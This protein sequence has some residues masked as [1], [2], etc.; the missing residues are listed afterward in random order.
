M[1][2]VLNRGTPLAEKKFQAVKG[3]ND[4]LPAQ[5][6]YW[7][8]IENTCK[9]VAD[10]Y[11]YNEIRF[12]IVEH[13]ALFERTIGQ[14][15][16]IV[17]KEMYTFDDHG[18]S[19]TLRPEG[20]AGCVRAAIE[21]GLLYNQTQR[22]WYMGPMY[23]HEQPQKGRYRQFYQFGI[24]AFGIPGPDIDAEQILMTARIF[25]E[26]GIQNEVSLQLNSL[27]SA[28][29]RAE[30]R[31]KLISYFTQHEAALDPDSRRRLVVNPLR[32]LDSKLP[33]LQELI[34]NAPKL[35]DFL[36]DAS[37]KHFDELRQLLDN[38]KL[39]YEINPRLVRGLDYYGLTVY[40]WTTT[41][42]G[43]QNALGAG[44]RYD[45]LVEQ[46]G[47]HSTPAVG[48]ALGLDRIVALV[49]AVYTPKNL[50]DAYLVLVGDEAAIA[51]GMIVAE[52]LRSLLPELKL[53]MNCGGGS[54]KN[55]FKRA[56]KS[57][58]NWALIIGEDELKTQTISAKNLRAEEPQ[59]RL[60]I[61]QLVD[62]FRHQI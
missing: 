51:T 5:S 48:F 58:A 25:Q 53:V 29:T 13:T 17:E 59:Q 46:L 4:L 20:T 49:E 22:L 15:T 32:I 30:H 35:T 19:L 39:S 54:F 28:Q 3:M 1:I 6:P 11:G 55:Q 27:G 42:L 61:E 41:K 36:D 44:G 43:A 2:E 24:E 23:R 56:D 47:G 50:V 40:E 8:Y 26:L 57:G 18:D 16:D 38:A 34:A 21:H 33:Q 60:T 12:P 7:Q 9:Q 31:Q 14:A 52:K 10:R 62:F 37:R 45:A